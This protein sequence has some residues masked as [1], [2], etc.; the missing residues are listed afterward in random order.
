V[1]SVALRLICER[2]AEISAFVTREYW[3]LDA[4]LETSKGEVFRA[5]VHKKAGEKVRTIPGESV[6]RMRMELALAEADSLAGDSLARVRSN[7]G[8]DLVV[9]GSYLS[10]KGGRVRL[11]VR[12]QETERGELLVSAAEEGRRTRSSPS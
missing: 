4:D 6:A 11:D 10:V 2:E 12:L 9:L 5:R 1:Q 3:T 7:L 8:A